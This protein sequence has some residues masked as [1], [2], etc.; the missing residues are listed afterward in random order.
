MAIDKLNGTTYTSADLG[1]VK[2]VV[3]IGGKSND[4]FI[5]NVNN[6]FHDDEFFF[7]LNAVDDIVTDET[8]TETSGVISQEI[9]GSTHEYYIDDSGRLKWDK[10]FYSCP[11]N[12]RVRFKVRKSAGVQFYYQGELTPEEIAD[13]C[14]RP[15]DIIGSYAVYCDKVNN[16]YKTGKLCHIPRPFVIDAAGNR[17]WCVM[18]YT[19]INDTS[20]WLDIT[21]PAEFMRSAD[22]SVGAVRLDPT[23]GYSSIGETDYTWSG[24]QNV[25]LRYGSAAESSGTSDNIYIYLKATYNQAIQLGYYNSSLSLVASGSITSGWSNDAWNGVDVSGNTITSGQDYY[26]AWHMSNGTGTGALKYDRVTD[27]C[28]YYSSPSSLPSTWTSTTLWF[29]KFSFYLEYTESG[30]STGGPLIGASA[31]VGGGVLCGQGNLI[32]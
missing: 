16:N 23:I 32:N 22:Y 29:G 5:P 14:E 27:S 28:Y 26:V 9:S 3:T 19:E 8:A 17:E 7:N 30:G 13:G 2:P 11:E 12:M 10:L 31:L 1:D 6:S 24:S 18:L 20:G 15:D 25:L 21:L 4:K